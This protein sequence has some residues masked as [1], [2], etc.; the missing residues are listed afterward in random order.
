M[1]GFNRVIIAGNLSRDPDLRYTVNKNAY[2]R[3]SVA[4]N[5]QRKDSNGNVQENVEYVNILVWGTTAENCGKYLKKG[6]GVLIEGRLQTSSYEA[7]DGSG[8]RYS[9]EVVAENIQFLGSG[10]Q[11]QGSTGSRGNYSGN[12]NPP[13]Q[14]NNYRQSPP[15]V[16]SDENFGDPIGE[17][18]FNDIPF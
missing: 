9:T 2:A 17:E 13:R 11:N 5:S 4:I 16:P 15:P 1:R 6:S 3:F 18:G 10:S 8:K 12:S 14:P 7:K